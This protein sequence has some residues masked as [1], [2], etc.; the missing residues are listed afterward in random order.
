LGYT[1]ALVRDTIATIRLDF[2]V[3]SDAEAAVLENHGYLLADAATRT[4]LPRLRRPAPLRIPHPA[5]LSDQKVREALSESSHKLLLGR[6]AF[7]AVFGATPEPVAS[8][9]RVPHRTGS[10]GRRVSF[11][12]PDGN[13]GAGIYVEPAEGAN[14]AGVVVIQGSLAVIDADGLNRLRD[15][16]YRVLVP[17]ICR[18]N[19]D[20]GGVAAQNILGAVRYLEESCESVGVIGFRSPGAL[21]LLFRVSDDGRKWAAVP[22]NED[23]A[24]ANAAVAQG[25]ALQRHLQQ[26]GV[27]FTDDRSGALHPFAAGPLD[28]PSMLADAHPGA[29]G[30]DWEPALALLDQ[31]LGEPMSA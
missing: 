9:D 16:G 2:D 6:G 31:H 26:A 30:D 27:D 24:I 22:L 29:S 28:I 20:F 14:G 1:P 17:D 21:A 12:R 15:R 18:G 11:T 13:V 5:W 8:R 3:F 23:G 25:D 19:V 10:V 4:H 7:R